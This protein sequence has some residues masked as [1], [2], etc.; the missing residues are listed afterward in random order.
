MYGQTPEGYYTQ[1]VRGGFSAARH[2]YH[3]R[4]PSQKI[5]MDDKLHLVDRRPEWQKLRD[6]KGHLRTQKKR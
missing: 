3:I 6:R 2:T 5:Q 1:D 4:R